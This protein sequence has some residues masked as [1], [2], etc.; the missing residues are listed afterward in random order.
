[1]NI[2]MPRSGIAAG[3]SL[4]LGVANTLELR[5]LRYFASAARAGN[6]ARAAQDMKVSPP[7]ISQRLRKLE[8]EFGTQLLIRHGRGVTPTPAGACLLEHFD[9]AM[10]LLTA[11]LVRTT[12]LSLM[13][14]AVSVALPPELGPLL[15]PPLMRQLHKSH[16][17]A[18]LDVKEGT[19]GI[20]EAWAL[21]HTVDV[22]IMQNPP[23]LDGWHMEPL[24][25]ERVGIVVSP[26]NIL[27]QVLQPLQ[28]RDLDQ[29]PL[30][31]LRQDHWVRR[32]LARAGFQR[33]L[34]LRP[35]FEMDS[36][37]VTKEMVRNGLGCAVLP[38]VA[39]Q[40]E[41]ASGTLVFRTIEHPSLATKHV[42]A[43]RCGT[44][45]ATILG[46]VSLLRRLVGSLVASG[47][48]PGTRVPKSKPP[49]PCAN[50]APDVPPNPRHL[51]SEVSHA[52]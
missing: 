34:R 23:V 50:G 15:V 18:S 28:L 7:A 3:T 16:P 45:D 37:A 36:L 29:I 48:W 38:G 43:H 4:G 10:R 17:L 6:L 33:G 26:Q 25:Q 20:L 49:V 8:E 46:V 31:L 44:R 39:V 14:S 19:S 13:R 24:V 1:M 35:A 51:A 40:D 5:E 11:P 22:A 27:A 42:I 52:I 9:A 2:L 41:L 32:L 30:I 12:E 21:S 47:A